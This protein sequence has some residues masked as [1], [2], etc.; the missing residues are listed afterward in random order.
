MC[1]SK[2]RPAK[3]NETNGKHIDQTHYGERGRLAGTD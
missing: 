1:R 2:P 3:I